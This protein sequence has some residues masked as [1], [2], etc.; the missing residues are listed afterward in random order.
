M[1]T[2]GDGTVSTWL[3]HGLGV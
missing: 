3:C 2:D 1:V